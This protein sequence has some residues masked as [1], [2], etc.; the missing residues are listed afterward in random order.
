VVATEAGGFQ[1]INLETFDTQDVMSG[2]DPDILS[3]KLPTQKPQVLL[4]LGPEKNFLVCFRGIPFL[5]PLFSCGK[6][7]MK[8][9]SLFLP[10]NR[11]L[12]STSVEN[13]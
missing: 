1:F 10:K 8:S 11:L 4:P 13:E 5:R 6:I 7:L 12:L 9:S 3:L 2:S